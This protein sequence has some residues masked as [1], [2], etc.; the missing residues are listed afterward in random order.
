MFSVDV[1]LWR[2]RL[3]CFITV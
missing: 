3:T 2:A 1:Y